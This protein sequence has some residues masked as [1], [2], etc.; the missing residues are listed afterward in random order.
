LRF[1]EI[2]IA[3]RLLGS[4]GRKYT[5]EEI[6]KRLLE[7]GVR[8]ATLDPTSPRALEL[9]AS[10]ITPQ[11]QGLTLGFEDS[12]IR[13]LGAKPTPPITKMNT[14]TPQAQQTVNTDSSSKALRRDFALAEQAPPDHWIFT[15]GASCGFVGALPKSIADSQAKKVQF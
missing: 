2:D 4:K 6:R 9:P 15:Q 14:T 5:S 3:R 11:N 1:A 13:R 10:G 12:R 8:D 7:L